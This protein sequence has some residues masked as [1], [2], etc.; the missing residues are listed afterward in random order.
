MQVKTMKK[1]IF[2]RKEQRVI[3][4]LYNL[5]DEDNTLSCEGIWDILTDIAK[6]SQGLSTDYGYGI[7][8]ID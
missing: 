5:F 4:E 7:E 1:L 2:T 8:I 3:A 6:G